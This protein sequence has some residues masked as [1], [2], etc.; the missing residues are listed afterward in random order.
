MHDGI[1]DWIPAACTVQHISSD[2]LVLEKR[3]N[4]VWPVVVFSTTNT[5][6]NRV[7]LFDHDC[8]WSV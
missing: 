4:R 7:G 5:F 3:D 6:S 1:K 2:D 8:C